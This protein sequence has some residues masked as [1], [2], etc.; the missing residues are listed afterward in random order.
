[1]FPVFNRRFG[2]MMA[3][4]FP[5]AV[6]PTPALA[7][8]ERSCEGPQYAEEKPENLRLAS[9][10]APRRT[11]LLLLN[12]SHNSSLFETAKHLSNAHHIVFPCLN[13]AMN[14]AD[15]Y[16]AAAAAALLN[17]MAERGI[18]SFILGFEPD[19]GGL[20]A[21]LADQAGSKLTGV[22]KS[23]PIA[24]G[25]NRSQF[26]N[27]VRSYWPDTD[28]A[29]FKTMQ[30]IINVQG[31]RIQA[32]VG[33]RKTENVHTQ[34]YWYAQ[35][36]LNAG[37]TANQQHA[38]GKAF[39]LS[40]ALG[41]GWPERVKTGSM[42]MLVFHSPNHGSKTAAAGAH[43]K[44]PAVQSLLTQK[45]AGFMERLRVSQMPPAPIKTAS[46]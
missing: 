13:K 28:P 45:V 19:F 35:F 40:D 43:S 34:D 6:L 31:G 20:A 37:G 9:L 25:N 36:L 5:S 21:H 30:T 24:S 44:A 15:K 1:M 10:G 3:V 38:P 39:D 2:L 11:A 46:N 17:Q 7:A 23:A 8:T 33:L 29:A 26:T 12:A 42:P 22:I 32:T 27:L 41:K 18:S 16:G 14:A 4:I